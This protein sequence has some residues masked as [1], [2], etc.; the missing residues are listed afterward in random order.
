MKL[1]PGISGSLAT[2]ISVFQPP[3][4][5]ST[6]RRTHEFVP[7]RSNRMTP[8]FRYTPAIGE[9]YISFTRTKSA[10]Q[11]SQR[12]LKSDSTQGASLFSQNEVFA[13]VANTSSRSKY[14]DELFEPRSAASQRDATSTMTDLASSG[15]DRCVTS[16]HPQPK[17]RSASARANLILISAHGHRRG[18]RSK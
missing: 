10:F 13:S 16:L 12:V 11:A 15:A 5:W 9:T 1:A 2:S 17:H 3:P 14:H 4:L 6:C 18:M 8:R 7:N